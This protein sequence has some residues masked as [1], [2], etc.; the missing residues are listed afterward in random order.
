MKG[1]R[2]RKRRKTNS[3]LISIIQQAAAVEMERSRWKQFDL[4]PANIWVEEEKDSEM[5]NFFD[6]QL[7][8]NGTMH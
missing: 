3:D 5:I 8:T 4:A 6:R 7:N 2:K 1:W